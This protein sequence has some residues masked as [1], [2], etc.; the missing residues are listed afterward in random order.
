[1]EL[2]QSLLQ[3]QKVSHPTESNDCTV[4]ALCICLDW[5]YIK[6]HS[7]LKSM[8]RKNNQGFEMRHLLDAINQNGKTVRDVTPLFK[9]SN[10]KTILSLERMNL[11]DTYLVEVRGHV[12]VVKNGKVQDWTKERCHR[13]IK[14]YR[15]E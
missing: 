13:I 8:G 10:V 15:I 14:V 12:L 11:R 7:L 1:M 3:Q 6:G 5:E 2:Y 4:R 9:N